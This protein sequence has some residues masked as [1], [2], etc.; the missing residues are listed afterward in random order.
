MT[1]ATPKPKKMPK[2]PEFSKVAIA[3]AKALAPPAQ[4]PVASASESHEDDELAKA[5]DS[6]PQAR[7]TQDDA[8]TKKVQLDPQ[9]LAKTTN[10]RSNLDPQQELVLITF[11]QANKDVFAWEPS[12]MPGIPR[13]VIEHKLGL[14]A[15]TQ[16][17][18][19]KQ[20]CYTPEK[21]AAI[22][23]EINHLLKEGFIRDVPFP[24]WLANPVMVKK[25]NG[26]WRMCVDYTDLNKSC[27]KDEYPLPRIDQIVD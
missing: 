10:I 1:L 13:E 4:E 21:R 3:Q 7:E 22:Q 11:L 26:T 27:P 16:P 12:D 20:R 25:P 24:E 8:S 23:Y 2:D 17:D 18:R 14:P 5:P 19:Q 15:G 6:T 9:D